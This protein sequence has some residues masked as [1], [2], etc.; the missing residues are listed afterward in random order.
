MLTYLA[1][2]ASA[3]STADNPE[4]LYTE[5]ETICARQLQA[6]VC[7]LQ[8]QTEAE[9]VCEAAEDPDK[10]GDCIYDEI[11]FAKAGALYQKTCD[12]DHAHA[13]A[14]LGDH[15]GLQ[16]D[17]GGMVLDRKKAVGY[18]AKACRLK[19]ED[20]C[21]KAGEIYA[22]ECRGL[23]DSCFDEADRYLSDLCSRNK[24]YACYY[25]GV[26]Y[27]SSFETSDSRYLE[28]IRGFQKAVD[29]GWEPAR[30]DLDLA[31]IERGQSQSADAPEFMQKGLSD[32]E[33]R[34]SQEKE[35][36]W[37][38]CH[39]LGRLAENEGKT[40]DANAAL[41]YYLKGC[42][43]KDA[44]SSREAARLYEKGER[45]VKKAETLAKAFRE[46]AE[47]YDEYCPELP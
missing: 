33:T 10:Y 3:A 29:L 13:C 18:Y 32:L 14:R 46:K 26:L 22:F 7:A 45:G 41:K 30:D 16:P 43:K 2:V 11:I 28:A 42:Q 36:C 44:E 24:G 9:T 6:E 34:C 19:Y 12:A 35:K 47:D 4:K 38:A 5:A 8:A 20:G 39:T 25:Q 1:A 27:R 37:G 40:P 15:W 31:L 17:N 21:Q 23:E